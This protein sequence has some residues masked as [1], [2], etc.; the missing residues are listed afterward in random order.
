M[1][2]VFVQPKRRICW[3]ENWQTEEHVEWE[4]GRK[5]LR[6]VE[7]LEVKTKVAS[8]AVDGEGAMRRLTWTAVASH[9]RHFLLTA[10]I[11]MQE[12]TRKRIMIQH[13]GPTGCKSF[14]FSLKNGKYIFMIL[15]PSEGQ[16]NKI[17][18]P[19]TWPRPCLFHVRADKFHE[20]EYGR[21][22]QASP[23]ADSQ[24]ISWWMCSFPSDLMQR[25]ILSIALMKAVVPDHE[26]DSVKQ[27]SLIVV[28]H[29]AEYI[30]VRIIR[31]AYNY[32]KICERCRDWV[33]RSIARPCINLKWTLHNLAQLYSRLQRCPQ[34]EFMTASRSS[35]QPSSRLLQL[36]K[37]FHVPDF[38]DYPSRTL[39]RIQL[40]GY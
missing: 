3:A 26:P 39:F 27:S 37:T 13:Y 2:R 20:N 36:Q 11:P 22:T 40:T 30:Y 12:A 32:R 28:S 18:E 35:R 24:Y 16:T 15:I 9:Q 14:G 5:S 21:S 10:V 1:E 7:G 33:C 6:R 23:W 38:L 34:L 8:A 4:R 29:V 25:A 31:Q 17:I 19:S